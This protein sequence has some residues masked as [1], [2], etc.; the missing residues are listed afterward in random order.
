MFALNRTH[1]QLT[2]QGLSGFALK[3]QESHPC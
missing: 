3:D 2:D 1:Q